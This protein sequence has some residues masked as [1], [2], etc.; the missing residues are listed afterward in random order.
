MLSK[1]KEYGISNQSQY[2]IVC[3]IENTVS[4]ERCSACHWTLTRILKKK[5]FLRI[6]KFVSG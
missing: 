3:I 6:A 5:N 2:N 1:K 4:D